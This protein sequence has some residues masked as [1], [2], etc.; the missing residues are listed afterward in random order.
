MNDKKQMEIIYSSYLSE[1]DC[2][3]YGCPNCGCSYKVLTFGSPTSMDV[4]CGECRTEYT[5][6]ADKVIDHVKTV[7]DI[8]KINNILVKYSGNEKSYEN[9]KKCEEYMSTEYFKCLKGLADAVV[10]HPREG[11]PKHELSVPDKRPEGIDGEYCIGGFGKVYTKEAGQRIVKMVKSVN[12]EFHNQ[13]FRCR[14]LYENPLWIHV[15]F[16]H[17][18]PLRVR[19]LNEMIDENNNVVTRD[20]L[21]KALTINPEE[22]LGEEVVNEYK[23]TR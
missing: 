15:D 19:V 4:Y 9:K 1:S 16:D 3:K 18:D 20:I 8:Q 7:I 11:I 10:T 13:S 22:Y 14:L 6:V 5:I 2:E 17:P 21:R 23:K 12:E